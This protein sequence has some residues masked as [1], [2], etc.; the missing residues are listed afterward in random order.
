M[1]ADIEKATGTGVTRT[2]VDK[3]DSSSSGQSATEPEMEKE[4]DKQKQTAAAIAA[5]A[6]DA[7]PGRVLRARRR[8]LFG[9]FALT[10]EVTDPCS[11]GN[12]ALAELA[13]DLHTTTTIANLSLAFYMLAMAFTPMWCPLR[14]TQ[15]ADHLIVQL[16]L[17]G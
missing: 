16:L 11:Y 4:Q 17:M 6:G 14:E 3:T 2:S 10:P 5:A 9:R 1:T 12:T 8:G 13:V 7:G 15:A